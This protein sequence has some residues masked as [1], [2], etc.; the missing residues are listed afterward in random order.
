[1]SRGK[2][3]WAAFRPPIV[4]FVPCGR[5]SVSSRWGGNLFAGGHPLVPRHAAQ[6]QHVVVH[7]QIA[8]VAA[9][10][11]LGPDRL[12]FLRHHADMGLVAPVVAETI[13]AEA[14]VEMA[15][16]SDVVFQLHVGPPPAAA[17]TSATATTSAA[18]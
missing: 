16:E 2:S 10:D 14:I 3:K 12:H 7:P 6:P 9:H 17:A 18:A 1:M 11:C 5:S 8:V 13:V 15:Q 4:L